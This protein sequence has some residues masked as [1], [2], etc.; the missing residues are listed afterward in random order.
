MRVFSLP[1]QF[2][3]SFPLALSK[4]KKRCRVGNVTR[5]KCQ[6]FI[7]PAGLEPEGLCTLTTVSDK[8]KKKKSSCYIIR[9]SHS[10]RNWAQEREERMLVHVVSPQIHSWDTSTCARGTHEEGGGD[11]SKDCPHY[12]TM[13]EKAVGATMRWVFVCGSQ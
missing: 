2:S 6:H 11:V 10:L 1:A 5:S 9:D 13:Q 8:K 12:T 3:P 4:E 7:R